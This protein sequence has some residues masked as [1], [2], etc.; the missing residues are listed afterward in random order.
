MFWR[1]ILCGLALHAVGGV[2][3]N[4]VTGRMKGN[5]SI[6]QITIWALNSSL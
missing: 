6:W 4:A 1:Q 5:A 2:W 3:A